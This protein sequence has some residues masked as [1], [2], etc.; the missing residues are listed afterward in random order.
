MRPE[1]CSS[2]LHQVPENA[3][4]GQQSTASG[5]NGGVGEA[6]IEAR[7]ALRSVQDVMQSVVQSAQVW[8]SSNSTEPLSICDRA[9]C[10]D[11]EDLS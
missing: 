1:R 11:D 2:I 4:A 10:A 9:T 5:G 8:L 6:V 3:A 7:R